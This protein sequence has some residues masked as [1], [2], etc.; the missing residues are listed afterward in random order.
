M[1]FLGVEDST[2]SYFTAQLEKC[3]TD[4]SLRLQHLSAE[5]QKTK[6]LIKRWGNG[7]HSRLFFRY[8]VY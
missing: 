1:I 3:S 6:M 8:R 5:S 4:F 7:R 2:K